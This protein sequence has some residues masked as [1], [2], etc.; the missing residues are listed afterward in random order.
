DEFLRKVD[1]FKETL[2]YR[3]EGT[4]GGFYCRDDM[5]KKVP[6]GGLGWSV[7]YADKVIQWCRENQPAQNIRMNKYDN[8]LEEFWCDK[9]TSGRH[10]LSEREGLK[11]STSASGATDSLV[12]AGM[13]GNLEQSWERQTPGK[14]EIEAPKPVKDQIPQYM[15]ESVAAR[16]K[17]S[18]FIGKLDPDDPAVK[19]ELPKLTEIIDELGKK[20]DEL[21]AMQAEAK[22][23]SVSDA[24]FG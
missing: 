1:I 3:D 11:E 7:K 21:A 14:C 10:G 20:Y 6:D 24:C 5:I 8:E 9:R 2:R 23:G 15:K 22:I 18:K 16:D 12:I 4:D 13:K 19:L 17:L